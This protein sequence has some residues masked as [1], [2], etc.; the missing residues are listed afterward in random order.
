[1]Y[2][3]TNS[4]QHKYTGPFTKKSDT[5]TQ[6]GMIV[7]RDGEISFKDTRQTTE[8]ETIRIEPR[9]KWVYSIKTVIDEGKTK[10]IERWYP[11][12]R[13]SEVRKT[14]VRNE[15]ANKD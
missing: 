14:V 5:M 13:I 3:A 7:I 9:S 10:T 11:M 6:Y 15:R 12:T 2:Q 1:M 8:F 4:I